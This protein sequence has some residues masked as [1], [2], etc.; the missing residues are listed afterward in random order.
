MSYE[1]IVRSD[2]NV[3]IVKHA[4]QNT[5]THVDTTLHHLLN[6][7]CT[8]LHPPTVSPYRGCG[9]RVSGGRRGGRVSGGRVGRKGVRWE[10]GEGGLCGR[11]GRE[12]I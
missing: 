12:G 10:G 1:C 3:I 9:G 4:Q 11:V 7:S 6:L 2:N 5:L 8:L